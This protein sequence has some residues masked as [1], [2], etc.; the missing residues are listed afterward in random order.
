MSSSKIAITLESG[1]LAE[2]DA[3]VKKRMFPNRSRAIQEAVK[4]KLTRLNQ[5]LLA[6]ECAK[7]DPE[8]EKAL[9]EESLTEDLS[10]WPEY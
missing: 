7:L 8:Y 5:S 1:M 4:E 6:Q 10:E 9:A 2:V 3:L